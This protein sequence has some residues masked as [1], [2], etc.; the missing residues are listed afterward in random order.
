MGKK[1][2]AVLL[3]LLFGI[4]FILSYINTKLIPELIYGVILLIY[5]FRFTLCKNKTQ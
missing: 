3:L 5:Y 1:P 2:D 4:Y